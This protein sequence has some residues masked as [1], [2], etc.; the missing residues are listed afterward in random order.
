MFFTKLFDVLPYD[1]PLSSLTTRPVCVG[2]VDLQCV[3]LVSA[4]VSF[5][6]VRHV[7]SE[8]SSPN[9]LNALMTVVLLFILWC[10]STTVYLIVANAFLF[11]NKPFQQQ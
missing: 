5:S 3:F 1:G 7:R 10:K 8:Q 9:C 11:C 2:L 4:M 6:S